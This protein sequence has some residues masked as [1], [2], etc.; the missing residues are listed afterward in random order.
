[1]LKRLLLLFLILSL[2][3]LPVLAEDS[4]VARELDI[5][6]FDGQTQLDQPALR[7]GR[8][9]TGHTAKRGKT[10]TLTA[11]IPEGETLQQLYM[12][13]SAAPVLA[14][15]HQQAGK[16]WGAVAS[17]E[18]PG[19]EF[20]LPVPETTGPVRLVLTFARA[21]A[22][23]V[24]E[25]RFY[26]SGKLSDALHPWQSAREADALLVVD[27]MAQVDMSALA[28]WL[29]SGRSVAVCA[30]TQPAA[31]V[32]PLT[33]AL[34][35]A[36]LRIKPVF[37][38]F[39][40]VDG[41]VKARLNSWNELNVEKS[42]V[43][44]IRRYQPQ[45]LI[46][47]DGAGQTVSAS[48]CQKASDYTF[49]VNDAAAH[50]L[51]IVPAVCTTADDVPAHLSALGERDCTALREWCAQ[52]FAS[53]LHG[54]PAAIPYP[55]ERLPDGYLAEGEFHFEDE[56]AG[57]WAYLS[58][59]VQVEI[60]RYE[61]P[62]FPRVWFEAEV[63]F[64]PEA[65]KFQQVLYAKA[66][67]PDQQIY[68]ETLAQASQMVLAING[69]YYPYRLDRKQAAGNILRNYK[70]LY[71]FDDSMRVRAF[72]NLDTVAF[73]DDGTLE[74]FSREETTATSLAKEG[75]VHDALSFGPYLARGGRL[76]IYN[77]DSWNAKEPRTAIGMVE[78]GHYHIL[79]VEGRMPKGGPAGL[80]INDL[81]M[82]MYAQGV[83]D[84]INL[85]GGSTSVLVFMGNKLNRTGKG[86]SI[87]Q[88][89]NQH[90]LFGVGTSPLV[91]TDMLTKR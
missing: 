30:L 89:R 48:A 68:P 27:D 39:K 64:K 83:T 70:V 77:G 82:L 80:N 90:E 81:A 87:G 8:D 4:P 2:L 72:P 32:L 37:G 84:A 45:L 74:V 7:D 16:R 56:K 14:E 61:Q 91:R 28:A 24:L 60:V 35:E 49:Q 47:G 73:R 51:W 9:D 52:P 21:E 26:A 85:D 3:P 88:P 76:R 23:T 44:W 19:Q 5:P 40:P 71:D 55:A 67:F 65:E 50:G 18:N 57:L 15:V 22:P 12:R 10:M 29:E 54:D 17:M 53:A 63:K 42:L 41:D 62:E 58:P 36:G 31:S 86:T 11:E 33:D 69:D 79:I 75:D 34:W 66:S 78:A 25:C 43:S 59:T 46:T 38:A 6:L 1:M 13:L 20:I